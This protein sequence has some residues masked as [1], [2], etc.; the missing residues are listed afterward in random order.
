MP[1][2]KEKPKSGRQKAAPPG[3]TLPKQAV[4]QMKEKYIRELKQS[5]EETQNPSSRA[6]EQ[7][8]QAG[9]WAAEEL[10]GA[11]TPARLL[12]R[13][14]DFPKEGCA[15]DDPTG[16]DEPFNAVRPEER[17]SRANAP[18]ERKTGEHQS[19]ESR[20]TADRPAS[21]RTSNEPPAFSCS[22]EAG[23]TPAS[24]SLNNRRRGSAAFY[25]ADGRR[26]QWAEQGTPISRAIL[27]ALHSK[28]KGSRKCATSAP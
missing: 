11:A 19:P 15:A 1:E 7:V 24:F 9:W 27:A 21:I 20:Q 3:T 26:G 23:S 18:K 2:F 4:R 14:K 12:Q 6:T 8:E 17:Q 16:P 22:N 10:A 13:Q 5:P 25:Q 28:G